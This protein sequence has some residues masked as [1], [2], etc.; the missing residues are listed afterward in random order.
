MNYELEIDE[1]AIRFLEKQDKKVKER[2]FS[3]IQ[4]AKRNPHHYFA[5]LEGRLDYK[6]RVG[7]YRVIAD[8]TGKKIMVTCIGHRRNIYK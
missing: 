2:I 4:E 3:K 6:L 7:N 1:E 8:I 5:R